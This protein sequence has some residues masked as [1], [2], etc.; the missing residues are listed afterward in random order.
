MDILYMV[1]S[2]IYLGRT[3]SIFEVR[4]TNRPDAIRRKPDSGRRKWSKIV[5]F[6]RFYK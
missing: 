2:R 5:V 4:P 3:T 1:R 6:W